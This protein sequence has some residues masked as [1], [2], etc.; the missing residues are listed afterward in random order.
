MVAERSSPESSSGKRAH[1]GAWI[2]LAAGLLVL[3][4]GIVAFRSV[5]RWLIRED[6]LV[7]SDA[8]VVL[9]GSMPARAEEAAHVFKMGYAPEIWVS[10]P[11]SP[12][13]ELQ[14]LG[15]SFTGEEVYNR[16]ILI[17]EGV[18]SAA[19]RIFPQPIENT[20]DEVQEIL[21]QM[22]ELN[23]QRVIIV[24][25]PPHTRRVRALWQKLSNGQLQMGAH[26]AYEDSFNA[27][28]W[29]KSTHD[30]FSVMRELMGLANIWAGLPVHSAKTNAAEKPASNR[31]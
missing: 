30:T 20:E 15:I 22:H 4:A 25:S 3:I 8:I 6:T 10:R 29:W 2:L 17:R 5:G 24:T 1:T 26:A 28:G 23:K 19:I 16:E 11:D 14:D 18:P 12:A 13:G 9:S 7:K 27:D 21:Q 31:Q